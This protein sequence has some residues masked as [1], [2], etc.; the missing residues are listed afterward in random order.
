MI[1]VTFGSGSNRIT[2]HPRV[3]TVRTAQELRW[4]GYVLIPGIFDGDHQFYLEQVGDKTHLIQSEE[5]TGLF[6]GKLT[7]PL[8]KTTSDQLNAVNLAL[9][10]RTE[11]LPK[12]ETP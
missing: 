2:L 7:Q 10:R 1:E 5:F 12:A 6:V 11:S 3:L 8:L 9:K 4:K